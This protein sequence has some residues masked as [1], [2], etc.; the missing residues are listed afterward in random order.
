MP[1]TMILY[2]LPD[3]PR[4]VAGDLA[5][6]RLRPAAALTK[7]RI[8]SECRSKTATSPSQPSSEPFL[9]HAKVRLSGELVHG[10]RLAFVK[11]GAY[12][13]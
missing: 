10:G 5:R 9:V 11:S 6:H 3:E 12:P 2:S 4:A 1:S 8:R 13:H 7:T